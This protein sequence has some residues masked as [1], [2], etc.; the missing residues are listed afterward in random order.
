MPSLKDQSD[1][2]QKEDLKDHD[3]SSGD[4]SIVINIIP[5][6]KAPALLRDVPE[7][8]MPGL[9]DGDSGSDEDDESTPESN[10]MPGLADTS[11]HRSREVAAIWKRS[12]F[13]LLVDFDDPSCEKSTDS[14][15]STDSIEEEK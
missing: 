10:K 8:L 12:I 3:S 13:R 5:P 7:L 2:D 9:E 6:K 1:Q 15:E 14:T 11:G 4:S